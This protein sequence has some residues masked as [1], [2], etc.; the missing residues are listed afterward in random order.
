MKK[1][2]SIL[3]FMV[4]ILT[5][6]FS[7]KVVMVTDAGGLGDKSFND[8]T[9]E[10]IQMAVREFKGVEG[11]VII[12]KEQTDYLS[13]LSRAAQNADLVVGVGFLMSDVLFSVAAQY[14]DT[15]FIGIDIEPSPGQIIPGNLALYTF[16]EEEAGFL[17]GYIAAS[18]S[19]T[20]KVGFIGGLEIPPVKRYEIGYKSGVKAYN[21]IKGKKVEVITGYVGSFTDA[22]KTKQIALSQYNLGADIVFT[23]V[24]TGAVID[25]AKEKGSSFYELPMNAPLHQIIDKYYE[26]GMGYFVIGYD[27]DQ[28][29]MAPGYVLTSSRKKVDVAT[30]EGISSAIFDR[31]FQSGHHVLG[32]A[33]DAVGLSQMKYTKGMVPNE[34]IAELAYLEKLVKD[35]EI[36]IPNNES[37]L[38]IFNLSHI[39]FPF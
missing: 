26:K 36:S 22:G 35:K 2:T 34:A 27:M 38:N 37:S 13:N 23:G 11:D 12:S 33:D 31:V 14:P 8:G 15:Y 1:F 7:F 6:S 10:G 20:N 9:W 16:K 19:K 17:L 32:I 18:M 39:T 21:D 3:L 4:L 28:D 25:A 29:F 5:S 24:T 30:F